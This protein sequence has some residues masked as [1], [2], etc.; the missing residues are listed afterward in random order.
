[1]QW[2]LFF[3]PAGTRV[4]KKSGMT[5]TWYTDAALME[6][7][8]RHLQRVYRRLLATARCGRGLRRVHVYPSTRCTYTL[9]KRRIFV[10]VRDATGQRFPDCVLRYVLLHELAH[11]ANTA[12]IGHDATFQGALEALERCTG[13]TCPDRVPENYNRCHG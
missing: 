12:T 7:D 9:D 10:R 5:S 11:V 13:T 6:A 1:M 2:F 4:K 8:D 3:F